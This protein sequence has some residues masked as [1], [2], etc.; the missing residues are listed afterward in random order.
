MKKNNSEEKINRIFNVLLDN[1]KE[2][3][4]EIEKE[5][6]RDCVDV[7]A[8]TANVKSLVKDNIQQRIREEAQLKIKV[9]EQRRQKVL[10]KMESWSVEKIKEVF[11]K[12]L[13]G[14]QGNSSQQQV[15]MAFRNKQHGQGE[16][17]EE[18]KSCLIDVLSENS[19]EYK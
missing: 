4:E 5:L 17:I 6:E 12:I 9:K 11:Q 13:V 10:E 7:N 2:T 8:F 15:A 14:Q 1:S 19:E 3:D 16:D 18:L